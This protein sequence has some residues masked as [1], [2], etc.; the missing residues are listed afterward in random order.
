M[1]KAPSTKDSTVRVRFTQNQKKKLIQ[2]ARLKG[3]DLSAYV[4]MRLIEI[5][6]LEDGSPRGG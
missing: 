2:N 3:L 4:R 5:D 1:P 6:G